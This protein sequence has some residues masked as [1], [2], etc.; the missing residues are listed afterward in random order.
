MRETPAVIQRVSLLVIA[1]GVP[2]VFVKGS[3]TDAFNVP[4]FAVLVAGVGLVVALRLYR[5]ITH[6]GSRL[7][8]Y[9]LWVPAAALCLPLTVSWVFSPY[10]QWALLG[11]YPRFQ[12][13]IPYL[14][15]AIF[16]LLLVDAFGRDTLPLAW[17][18]VAAGTIAGGYGLLQSLGF[19][20]LTW[21]FGGARY[22]V[23]ASTGGH[24][25]YTGGF[26]AI[27]LPL[28][29]YLWVRA[30]RG[31][32]IAAGSAVLIM[33]GLITSL[34]QGPWAA[35]VGGLA[36][37]TGGFLSATRRHARLL[38]TVATVGIAAVM[39]TPVVI[40]VLLP[41]DRG[42]L[43]GGTSRSRGIFWRSAILMA[44]D[45]PM[46]GQGPN[47]F[48]VDG[49]RYR[50]LEDALRNG[51]GYSDDP[52]SIPM[53][54]LA[55]AGVLGLLG[56]GVVVAWIW[57]RAHRLDPGDLLGH[58]F[59]AGAVAYLLQGLVGIDEPVQRAGLWVVL[60]GLAA[61]SSRVSPGHDEAP[62]SPS[63]R[64]ALIAGILALAV[65]SGAGYWSTRFVLAD[66]QVVAAIRSFEAHE[67]E[68][69]H[70][71]LTTALG[72]RDEFEFREVYSE[73]LGLAALEEGIAGS[74]LIARMKSNNRY[75]ES[76]PESTAIATEAE[77]LHYWGRYSDT[78]D[79]DA[80]ERFE[81]L[82]Q[83]DPE[84]PLV[85]T[86]LAEVLIDLGLPTQ[87]IDVLEPVATEIGGRSPDLWSILAVAYAQVN[88][89]DEALAALDVARAA[90][91]GTSCRRLIAEVLLL[92]DEA[93]PSAAPTIPFVCSR[94]LLE[95]YQDT[96]RDAPS[97]EIQRMEATG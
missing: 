89:A 8:S 9:G 72:F 33:T 68:A 42:G 17:A 52:H 86:E 56:Y 22:P 23:T 95:W 76:H 78:G 30:P 77:L 21:Y 16:G 31:R 93:L 13:L 58:A 85:E 32:L 38:A 35:G 61:R 49:V 69:G 66:R 15:F 2:L 47:A 74:E 80:L 40:G 70:E 41:E 36:V 12:G 55:N 88:R 75:L 79:I 19:D 39:I 87:A 84:N 59:A 43:F 20:P 64:R 92:G 34:S 3:F 81:R 67:I 51:H 53:S 26:L 7:T 46:V 96:A 14:L 37:L 1:V 71:Q 45:S 44:A 73:L 57:R 5:I 90:D 10:K 54:F 11:Q 62:P 4:K 97:E 28:A 27:A 50:I 25:N 65:A 29:V 82:S 83:L 91:G 63:R 94:G 6:P 48:A 60:A 18:I 24:P